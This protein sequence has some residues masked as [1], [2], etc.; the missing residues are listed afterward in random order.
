MKYQ[1]AGGPQ[2]DAGIEVAGRRYEVGEEVE[3]TAKQAEWL[4]EQGYVEVPGKAPAAK[5]TPVEPEPAPAPADDSVEDE[6][7]A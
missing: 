1:V 7:E 4:L 3:M 2:G 5:P 6:G